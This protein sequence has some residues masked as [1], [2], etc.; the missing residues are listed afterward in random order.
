M[1]RVAAAVAT[2][3]AAA[4]IF[5]AAPAQAHPVCWDPAGICNKL[6]EWNIV[7]AR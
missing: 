7:C 2:T 6:C 3:I 1:R 5:F 4:T